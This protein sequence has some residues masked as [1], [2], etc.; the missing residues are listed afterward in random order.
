LVALAERGE[1]WIE[2]EASHVAALFARWLDAQR[3]KQPDDVG[4]DANGSPVT[5]APASDAPV[6]DAAP[7]DDAVTGND[8]AVT[9][10]DTA[11][12]SKG[13]RK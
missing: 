3:R 2:G 4:V 10:N 13:S 7:S 11:T 8:D 6:A 9:G 1:E 5:D 12:A